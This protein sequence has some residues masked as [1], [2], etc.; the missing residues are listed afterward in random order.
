M[1]F[2]YLEKSFIWKL[3]KKYNL[4][5]NKTVKNFTRSKNKTETQIFPEI[6]KSEK[7]FPQKFFFLFL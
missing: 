1:K 3:E 5:K 7:K 4:G 6:S 2:V